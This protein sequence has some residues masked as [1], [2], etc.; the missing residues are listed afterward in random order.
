MN[1]HQPQEATDL[2]RHSKRWRY[3][4]LGLL[5]PPALLALDFSRF[6][7]RYHTFHDRAAAGIEQLSVPTQP[8]EVIVVLT[9]DIGRIPRALELLKVRGSERLIISGAAKGVS[10]TE[11]VNQQGASTSNLKEVWK[12]ITLDS[13]SSSTVENATF[14]EKEVATAPLTRMILVTSDYHM[15][16]SLAVFRRVFGD[17]EIIPYS[18]PSAVSGKDSL[19][20]VWKTGSEYWKSVIYRM[21]RWLGLERF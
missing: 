15:D 21:T 12:K 11:L 18:V 7:S 8:G 20:F 9:G 10:L 19:H 4:W 5:I 17:L 16:R 14:T 3:L 2:S 13:N 1:P 6:L